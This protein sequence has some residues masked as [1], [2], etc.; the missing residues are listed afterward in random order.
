MTP[1]FDIT[2][3]DIQVNYSCSYS[4]CIN[5]IRTRNCIDITGLYPNTTTVQPCF[6]F[7][8]QVFLGFEDYRTS[9]VYD[10]NRNWFGGFGGFCVP[11]VVNRSVWLPANPTWVTIGE[12]LAQYIGQ[13]LNTTFNSFHYE[14]K[15]TGETASEGF[16]SLKLWY[17]PPTWG[18]DVYPLTSNGTFTGLVCENKT[19][20]NT[21]YIESINLS[22]TSMASFNF[23]FPSTTM[24]L[25]FDVKR[26]SLPEIQYD[27]GIWCGKAC[28]GNCTRQ[29]NGFYVVRLKDYTNYSAT[30]VVFSG[31]STDNWT[32]VDFDMT[33]KVN[34]N[35]IYILNFI[36]QSDNG[37]LGTIH[38]MN[39]ASRCLGI[40]ALTYL[41]RNI[42]KS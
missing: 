16:R 34:T 6:S 14:A 3:H 11:I 29:P 4:D 18:Y 36:V 39:N 23:T 33:N 13:L 42:T 8:E 32:T 24:H 20:G 26:C 28:F 10:C 5:N 35:D 22:T 19:V 27:T 21:G 40:H 12:D 9:E 2:I 17:N 15:I 41:I 38:M 25:R 37:W 7:R 1:F 30:S 31:H